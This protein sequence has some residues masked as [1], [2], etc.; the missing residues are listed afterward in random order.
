[1]ITKLGIGDAKFIISISIHKSRQSQP[2]PEKGT[3]MGG[4]SAEMPAK[5]SNGRSEK[6]EQDQKN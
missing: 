6:D 1:M 2:L 5:N 3:E 4:L